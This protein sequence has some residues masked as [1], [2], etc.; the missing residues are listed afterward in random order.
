[1]FYLVLNSLSYENN[2]SNYEIDCG[3]KKILKGL[4]YAVNFLLESLCPLFYP[5]VR[6]SISIFL[7]FSP[8]QPL[9]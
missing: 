9:L 7:P 3:T 5:R 1:M 2:L 6:F 8:C 4:R